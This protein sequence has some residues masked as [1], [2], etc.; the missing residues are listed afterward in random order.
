M[1][2]LI[3]LLKFSVN[4]KADKATRMMLNAPNEDRRS[5]YHGQYL[6]FSEVYTMLQ[7]IERT[8]K[9]NEDE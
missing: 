3:E 9:S 5:F 4:E 2:D 6:A 8:S 7:A 1:N